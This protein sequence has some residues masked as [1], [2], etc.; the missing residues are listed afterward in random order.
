MR[1]L[2]I[3]L[4]AFGW[5]PA[6]P[7]ESNAIFCHCVQVLIVCNLRSSSLDVPYSKIVKYIPKKA[8]KE[9]LDDLGRCN[10]ETVLPSCTFLNVE[11]AALMHPISDVTLNAEVR[12]VGCGLRTQP[13]L[14][15]LSRWNC[16]RL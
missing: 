3:R 9:D 7:G 1:V 15:W 8:R 2:S 5:P 14:F 6:A 4:V 16:T 12:S 10:S 13:T 11:N